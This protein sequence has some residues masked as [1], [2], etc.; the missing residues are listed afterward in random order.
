[1]DEVFS[2]CESCSKEPTDTI[3][4]TRFADKIASCYARGDLASAEK[5]LSF[6]EAEARSLGDGRG[7]LAV[8]NEKV[9]VCRHLHKKEE[10]IAVSREAAA[11]VDTLGAGDTVSAATVLVNC[12]T[13]LKAFGLPGE[14]LPLYGRAR[15]VYEGEKG[16]DPYLLSSLYNNQATTLTDLG[17]LPAAEENY[18]RAIAL[19]TERGGYDGE[20]GISYVNLAF[21]YDRMEKS[22]E[23]CLDA[24]EA[25]WEYLNSKKIEQNG[26]YARICENC[27]SAFTAFG[28]PE[29][30][31][32]LR[33]RARKLYEAERRGQER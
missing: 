22:A 8:L 20:V 32:E 11:L 2:K 9:G 26:A 33:E 28:Q 5:L 15:A 24:L 7:L 16:T 19:L 3:N 13:T 14:A 30:E 12:A 27:A 6:W 29:R 18:L 4:V 17:D 23:D 21:L 31:R 10:G 25:G 1:M